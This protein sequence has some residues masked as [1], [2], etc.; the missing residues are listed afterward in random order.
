MIA[1]IRLFASRIAD[2]VAAA[3]QG[4]HFAWGVGCGCGRSGL[5]LSRIVWSFPCW[6]TAATAVVESA[7]VK[8]GGETMS[9]LRS[10]DACGKRCCGFLRFGLRNLPASAGDFGLE[11]ES[12]GVRRAA[13]GSDRVVDCYVE[14]C[15]PTGSAGLGLAGVPG[16][17]SGERGGGADVAAGGPCGTKNR[18]SRT[19]KSRGYASSTSSLTACV[20]FI[21]LY[22]LP[23]SLR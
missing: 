14:I 13:C 19:G 9:W 4:G 6:R 2:R 5:I 12:G 1:T 16:V 17:S 23:Q 22:I 21:D 18:R 10:S 3:E 11:P 7:G 20:L 15:E 8:D